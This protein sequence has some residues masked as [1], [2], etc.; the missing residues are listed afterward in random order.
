LASEKNVLLFWSLL[1][2]I[3]LIFLSVLISSTQFSNN[4]RYLRFSRNLP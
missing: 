4:Q 1:S 3:L 2:L